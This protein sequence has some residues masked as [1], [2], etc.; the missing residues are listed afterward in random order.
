M[1][2]EIK[3]KESKNVGYFVLG[4]ELPLRPIWPLRIM[5]H[6]LCEL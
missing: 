1:A 6:F 2:I 5:P 4:W 3:E